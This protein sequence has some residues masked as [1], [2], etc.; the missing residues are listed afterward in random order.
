MTEASLEYALRLAVQSGMNKAYTAIPC[1]ITNVYDDLKSLK[2]D[3]QPVVN[4]IN[5]DGSSEEHAQLMAV[6]VQMPSGRISMVSFPLFKGDVGLCVFC[7][8]AIDNFKH[9]NGMPTSP[10]RIRRMDMNDAVFIPGVGPFAKSL[11]NPAVRTLPHNTQDL[12]VAHNIGHATEV[13]MR[14]TQSGKISFTT[15]VAVEI[16][17]PSATLNVDNTTWNGNITHTGTLTS[18]GIVYDTHRHGSSP[19]PS[20]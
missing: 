14:L 10:E 2:V 18:N 12:V 20:N 15:D 1:V 9:G 4:V 3:V 7:H 8:S 13:E 5:D 19:P 6:P 17:S 11:N 16:N